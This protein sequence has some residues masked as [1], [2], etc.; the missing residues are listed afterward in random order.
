[1]IV[2]VAIAVLPDWVSLPVPND[3]IVLDRVTSLSATG[4]AGEVALPLAIFPRLDET[5]QS[6][7][8]QA[9]FDLATKPDK[10]LFL[11]IPAVNRRIT[12]DLNGVAL[13][14]GGSHGLWIGPMAATAGLVQ[15]PRQAVQA[16]RN[17]LTIVAETG[18]FV[19][20]TYLSKMYIGTEASIASSYTWRMFFGDQL[21]TMALAAHILLG[22][23]L[24]YAYFY[25]PNDP[26]FA[27]LA[28]FNVV[29]II[30]ATGMFVGFQP[31]VQ[32]LLPYMVIML[33]AAGVILVGVALSLIN[34][35][36]PR[37]LPL[38][39][40]IVIAALL[41]FAINGSFLA[42]A[43]SAVS[44][45]VITMVTFLV[46]VSLVA[47]GAIRN[48][49]PD[50]RLML[51]PTML[52]AWFAVRDGYVVATLPHHGFNL[53]V[54]YARPVFLAAMTVVM[55]RRMAVS[56]DQLD[57]ANETLS[58]K[59]AE[60]GAELAALHRQERVKVGNLIR[61]QERQRLTHDLHDGISGHLASIIALSERAGERPIELAAREALNDLRLVIYSLDL[62][63]RE[64]PLALANFRERLVPQLQRL[65]VALEWSIAGLP[66]VSG[67][68]PG[69]ALAI[70]RILQEAIT[71]A[72]KHGPARRIGI[73]GA[74]SPDGL[75]AIVVE[76]DG[77]PFV[78]SHGGYGLSNM[79]RR[80]L[81]LRGQ[82]N[83]ENT[84]IGVRLTLLLPPRLPDF[85]DEA[86][87][88][89]HQ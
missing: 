43:I 6:A 53:L 3:A 60:Q 88:E 30:V 72:V 76:N 55:M 78:E 1:M 54:T 50:A 12:L 25:R 39:V 68:T 57:D 73:R 69:N 52:L 81:H 89:F 2:T 38:L 84:D 17:R 11:Y 13:F 42:R 63:D 28:A 82:I 21:K 87:A 44:S 59:L 27:W 83:I 49:S 14:D 31:A 45:A 18:R 5:S 40:V 41:P 29:S 77:R 46:S 62:G 71:N 61:D 36:P 70:L 80:A 37:V 58:V 47:W 15:L 64:L 34:V 85:E 48:K 20:P 26:L 75:V 16:G 79:R 66:D 10:D 9:N 74:L 24:I 22:I 65:G 51:A 67:V 35:R 4:S 32:D 23:G 19:F 33:P 7:R 56:L 86:A 8:Y